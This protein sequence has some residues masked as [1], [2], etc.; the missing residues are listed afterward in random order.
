MNASRVS[1]NDSSQN[2]SY[3]HLYASG[4]E[5]KD[6]ANASITG[7]DEPAAWKGNRKRKRS[8]LKGLE[9]DIDGENVGHRKRFRR[10]RLPEEGIRSSGG[11]KEDKK[12]A[13]AEAS[14]TN[15]FE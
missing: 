6:T 15:K 5:E 9:N 13:A 1:E 14:E 12:F 2:S 7:A 10:K 11:E 4:R 8:V 3:V